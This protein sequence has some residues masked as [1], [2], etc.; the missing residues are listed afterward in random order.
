MQ[1]SKIKA[2][3]LTRLF[4]AIYVDAIDERDRLGKFGHFAQI[5]LDHGLAASEVLVVGDNA[6]SEIAAGARL[7]VRTVQ[8]LRTEAPYAA[9]AT[10]HIR[11]L[12]ELQE[13][14]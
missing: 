13:L 7:G 5:M 3:E 12:H 8:I 2:L 9:N 11:Y 4:T 1:E 10:N 14:L 6:D